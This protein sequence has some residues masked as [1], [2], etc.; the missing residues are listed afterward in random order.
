MA[1]ALSIF[2]ITVYQIYFYVFSKKVME[3]VY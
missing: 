1:S 3:P 2:N